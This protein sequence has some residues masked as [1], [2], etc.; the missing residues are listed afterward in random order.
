LGLGKASIPALRRHGR[1]P[2]TNISID[3]H[4]TSVVG[5]QKSASS[6]AT[7]DGS[8]EINAYVI[9]TRLGSRRK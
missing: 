2:C 4:G 9:I 6:S 3:D 8:S 5:S 7:G 1:E